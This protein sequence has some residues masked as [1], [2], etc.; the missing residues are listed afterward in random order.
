MISQ[1]L[2]K[3]RPA[4]TPLPLLVADSPVVE[5]RSVDL[6]IDRRPILHQFSLKI[7]RRERYVILGRSGAGKS[8][9]LRLILG[10]LR[11]SRGEILFKGQDLLKLSRFELNAARKKIGMVYQ[12]S[13]LIS[14]LS[15]HDNVA[16]PLEELTD[17][18]PSEIDDM[19]ECKL[20]MVGMES[21]SRLMP[22]E[23]SGG[24]RKRVAI[25]RA[26]AL[27]PELLLFDEPSAG[28]D[29][30]ISATIDALIIDLA[31]QGNT[32][33]VIVTHELDSA[34]R[35]AT[36]MGMLNEGKM[37][38][39]DLPE[40]FLHSAHPLVKQFVEGYAGGIRR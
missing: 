32:T 38:E 35:V 37:I 11:P 6:D 33:S 18:A 19:V 29:P 12:S 27:D 4:E 24:M 40:R 13:A 31:Q 14:Y 34:F 39:E 25:A 16:L 2:E 28:L 17:Y 10:V 7:P 15:V 3:I 26:L 36:R 8:T 21:S 30:V 1:N 20:A 9:L 5:L 22:Y 23:L